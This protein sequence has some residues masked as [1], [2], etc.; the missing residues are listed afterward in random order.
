M[1]GDIPQAPVTQKVQPEVKDV[2]QAPQPPPVISQTPPESTRSTKPKMQRKIKILIVFV[3]LAS[4]VAGVVGYYYFS[5]ERF[6]VKDKEWFQ[7]GNTQEIT[8]LQTKTSKELEDNRIGDMRVLDV[9]TD[10]YAEEFVDRINE[11]GLKWTRLSI[12]WFDWDEIVENGAYSKHHIYPSQDKVITDLK[13]N[14]IRVKYTLLF[15]DSEAPS[16]TEDDEQEYS[17]FKTEEEIERYL[18]YVK[19]IVSNFKGRIEYY[20]ILNEQNHCEGT[21]QNVKLDDYINLVKRV[22][23]IIREEDPNAKIVAGSVADLRQA[24]FREY[25]LGFTKSDAMPLV[26]GISF[27]PMYGVSPEYDVLRQYYY[28]YPSLIQE[29]KDT[30]S[31]HGFK[32]EY[33]AD[34]LVW[35][36]PLDPNPDENWTYSETKATKYNARGIVINLRMNLITGI[37]LGS[38]EKLPL[39]VGSIKN[40]ATIMAGTKPT[41]LIIEIQSEATNIRNYTFSL[42][43]GDNLIALWTDGVAVDEDPGV[44]ADLIYNGFA[45]KEVIAVDVLNGYQQTLVTDGN[46]IK[47]LIVRDYPLILRISR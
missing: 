45:E 41:S 5:E 19:F 34:E 47:D 16:F 15:W 6:V 29:I 24:P 20:E 35:R 26:D 3:I 25:L 33:F 1:K 43:N 39:M 11:V 38:E 4:L 42:S 31:A 46:T 22:V 9:F 32:G 17:R 37:A 2:S 18:D 30:S 44:N 10:D 40:L 14:G 7:T 13:N 23:P 28:E 8:K 21:Q 12:D 36:T 27:H